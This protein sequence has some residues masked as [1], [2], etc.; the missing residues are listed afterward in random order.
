MVTRLTVRQVEVEIR[1]RD[2]ALER[3]DIAL[4]GLGDHDRLLENLLLHVMAIIALLDPRGRG[5]GFDDLAVDGLVGAVVD[6]DLV[7][8]DD[9]PVA[10]LEIGD[11]LG[12]RRQ[13]QR[14][15]TEVILTLAIADGQRR[16]HAR[17]DDLVWIILEQESDGKGPMETRQNGRNRLGR[18]LAALH[19]ARDQVRNHFTVGL[20]QEFAA[21]GQQLIP[22]RLEILDD[23][24]VDQR[25][26][27]RDVGMGIVDRRRAVR[28]PAGVRDTGVAVQL[29]SG[30]L[31]RQI[32][33]LAF[34]S[35]T[36]ELSI[37]HGADAG[38]VITAIFQALQAVE[39]ALSH[40]LATDDPD[41]SAHST[42]CPFWPAA[43][44]ESGRPS[45]QIPFARRARSQARPPRHS[46]SRPNRR[47]RSRRRR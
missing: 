25:D 41:N 8:L 12:Q 44:P 30:Q 11:F 45:R 3:A 40:D 33:Q 39:Q 9:G 32:V 43:E 27:P 13:R 37:M 4:E 23:A 10:L 46:S 24:V 42:S 6:L 14:V 16:A 21:I 31:A 35:A 20:A 18:R 1:Q 2:L 34:G 36:F 22:Q 26:R 15:R 17:T 47:R 19:F 28:R 38:R 7:A 29:C 5:A